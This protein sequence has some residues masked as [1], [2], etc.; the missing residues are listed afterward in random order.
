MPKDLRTPLVLVAGL[1][2][3]AAEAVAEQ[4]WRDEPGT[5]LVHHNL[6][7]IADGVL[8]RRVRHGRHDELVTLTLVHGCISC[9]LREDLLP[10]LHRLAERPDVRRVVVQLDPSLEPEAVCWALHHVL[11]EDR[12]LDE[13]TRVEAVVTS[14]DLATLLA[15]VTGDEALAERGLGAAAADERTVAQVAI[16][17]VE[18][19]DAIVLAGTP[20]DRWTAARTEAVLDRL[21]PLSVRQSLA[22]L[23][24]RALLADLPGNAR[25]GELDDAHGPLLRGQPPLD[26]DCGVSVTVFG[27]RRP[28]H[29][30]RLHE[31][32]DVLLDG[33][34]RAKGRVWVASQPDVALWVES[35]GGGLRI[36]HAGPW[37][38]TLDQDDWAEIGEERRAMA[39][40]TWDPYYGDRAQDV[41][42]VAHLADPAELTAAL[43]NALLTDEELARGE[44]AWLAYPDPFGSWHVDP[45][46]DRPIDLPTPSAIRRDEA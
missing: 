35:A 34:V 4:L 5:A 16:G 7:G 17:Q 22:A 32:L 38:A 26:T 23:D 28:F 42:V 43:R 10:L 19:A 31:A 15:D 39:A 14:V 44:A 9:T 45:C 11:V 1:A 33:V 8:R 24:T 3:R 41:V 30:Q 21:A 2:G 36:G 40:L 37:L 29:P 18:F 13:L 27:D 20:A 25:R 46:E 6:R 12:T